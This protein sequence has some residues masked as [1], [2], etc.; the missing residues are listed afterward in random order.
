MLRKEGPKG[1]E[2]RITASRQVE[3]FYLKTDKSRIDS[4]A[5]VSTWLVFRGQRKAMECSTSGLFV[6]VGSTDSPTV[7]FPVVQLQN[8]AQQATSA[9]VKLNMLK[10]SVFRIDIRLMNASAITIPASDQYD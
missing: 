6:Q 4:E 2:T 7:S 8:E 3:H 9:N 5:S 10:L 1:K